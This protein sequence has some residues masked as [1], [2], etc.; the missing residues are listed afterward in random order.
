MTPQPRSWQLCA[1]IRPIC[2]LWAGA[3]SRGGGDT[4][5]ARTLDPLVQNAPC[6][7]VIVRTSAD[8]PSLAKASPEIERV[9]V[10]AAGGP[11]A[12]LAIDLAL[13][14]SPEVEITAL[15]IA[16]EVTRTRWPVAGQRAP[17]GDSAPWADEPRVQGKVVQSATIVQGHPG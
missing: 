14:L 9:L 11:N 4:W 13:T 10:P 12:A 7:V 6:D 16:R 15:N 1:A 5:W 8:K 17:A 3:A 2:S